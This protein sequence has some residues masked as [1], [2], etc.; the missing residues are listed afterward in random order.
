MWP[1]LSE[2]KKFGAELIKNLPDEI[3]REVECT[4][5]RNGKACSH[6]GCLKF[7]KCPLCGR[8]RGRGTSV[9]FRFLYKE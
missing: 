4:K 1:F 3:P 6:P 8:V 2:G 7:R 5:S 9:V